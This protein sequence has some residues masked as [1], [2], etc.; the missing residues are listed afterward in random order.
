MADTFAL[1]STYTVAAG[2]TG[3]I[4][5]N[6]IPQTYTDLKLIISSQ[7]N[8]NN[9][10]YGYAYVSFNSNTSNYAAKTF[11]GENASTQIGTTSDTVMSYGTGTQWQGT[12]YFNNGDMYFPNYSGSDN[13]IYFNWSMSQGSATDRN[14]WD[15]FAGVWTNTAA[16]TSL[17][18]TCNGG[19]GYTTWNANTVFSL[20]GIKNA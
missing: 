16:I 10:N 9:G 20:Y 14:L 6:S 15:W 2:G 18:I 5:F 1:I 7:T 3:T 13:K 4:S 19:A 12:Y 11:Y 17:T 8:R